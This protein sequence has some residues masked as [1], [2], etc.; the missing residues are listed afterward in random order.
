MIIIK[1]FFIIG[2]IFILGVSA[3]NLP[4]QTPPNPLEEAEAAVTVTLLA[5]TLAAQNNPPIV[6]QIPSSTPFPT[7]IPTITPTFTP[8]VPMATVSVNTN[9]R[10]GPGIVYDLIGALLVG[11]QAV[12]VGKFTSGNY[13]IINNPDSSG[14]C[15]LWGQY[16]TVTGNTAGLPEYT[17]PP[18]PT[19]TKTP[20]P[21]PTSTPPPPNA[22]TGFTANKICAPLV[23]PTYNYQFILQWDD[24]SNEEGYRVYFN[25]GLIA[26]LPAGTTTYPHVIGPLGA[27]VSI[28]Y[29]VE[30]FNATGTSPKASLTTTCP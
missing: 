24:T 2:L 21:T 29:D 27:G 14:T 22:P 8:G 26:T 25:S 12:V 16:A 7:D 30:A 1:K 3:C 28:S 10:T 11:E 6:T 20:T 13:W 5:M 18:T 17:Q 4:S 19:P 23:P 15:W 9:C